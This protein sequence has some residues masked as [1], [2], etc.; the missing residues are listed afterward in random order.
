MP[1]DLDLTL[2]DVVNQALRD[3]L[4]KPEVEVPRFEMPTF[5]DPA[6]LVHREPS[7]FAAAEE[8]QDHRSLSR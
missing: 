4:A 8:D 2:S 1:A 3:A 6:S 7:D 5:G